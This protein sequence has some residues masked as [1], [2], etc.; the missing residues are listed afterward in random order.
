VKRA[1]RTLTGDGRRN[2]GDGILHTGVTPLCSFAAARP[3]GVDDLVHGCLVCALDRLH[4]RRANGELRPWLFAISHNLFIS[5]VRR[6]ARRPRPVS[7]DKVDE[8]G[9]GVRAS[10]D[11]PVQTRDLMRAVDE[12]PEEQRSVLLLISVE[13]YAQVAVVLGIPIGQL[14]RGALVHASG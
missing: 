1:G 14:C 13:S 4:A 10:Q 2:G 7:M 3:E 12:L 8:N 5:G 9:L 6:D 11:D